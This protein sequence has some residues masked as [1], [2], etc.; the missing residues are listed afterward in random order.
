MEMLKPGVPH[1]QLGRLSGR[2][3]NRDQMGYH[4]YRWT[5]RGDDM[6]IDIGASRDG[7]AWSTFLDGS[8]KHA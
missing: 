5:V 2:W 3:T 1:E 4:R 6:E 8:Y 7:I